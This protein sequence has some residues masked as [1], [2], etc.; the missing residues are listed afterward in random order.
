MQWFWDPG[1]PMLGLHL[2]V[3]CRGVGG[4]HREPP[5]RPPS[6]STGTYHSAH[7][8]WQDVS[9]VATLTAGQMGMQPGCVP[10]GSGAWI[11]EDREPS[12]PERVWGATLETS[13]RGP[14]TSRQACISR[15]THRV[16]SPVRGAWEH[17]EEEDTPLTLPRVAAEAEGGLRASSPGGGG[18]VQH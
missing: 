10:G 18:S 6:R 5:G 14:P 4:R 8:L 12:P 3:V 16:P 11:R 7:I 15:C 17:R 2:V 13:A 1:S 9:R